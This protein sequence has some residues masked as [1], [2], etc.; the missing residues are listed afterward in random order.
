[1]VINGDCPVDFEQMELSPSAI[2]TLQFIAGAPV[3]KL[4]TFTVTPEVLGEVRNVLNQYRK[5]YIDRDFRSLEVLEAL[6]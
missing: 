2:Y 1:M 3:E 6:R 4:Y 5:L